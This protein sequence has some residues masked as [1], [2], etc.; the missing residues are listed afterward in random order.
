MRLRLPVSLRYV[1]F[2]R[3]YI[4]LLVFDQL[5]AILPERSSPPGIQIQDEGFTYQGIF[6]AQLCDFLRT[7]SIFWNV[8][9][10]FG[11]KRSLN[12]FC[13]VARF[14]KRPF[15]ESL[16]YKISLVLTSAGGFVW[17]KYCA[18]NVL[19]KQPI[20]YQCSDIRTN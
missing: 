3:L 7:V 12:L 19:P 4:V 2:V 6:K 15:L 17:G 1:V 10:D 9:L 20:K 8:L 5:K 16:V 18:K 13:C 14:L 11:L